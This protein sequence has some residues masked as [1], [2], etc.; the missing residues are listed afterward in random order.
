M[1]NVLLTKLI[2]SWFNRHVSTRATID[3]DGD[4][5]GKDVLVGSDL[6]SRI[7]N[8]LMHIGGCSSCQQQQHRG[9]P[10]CSSYDFIQ[11]N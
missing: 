4:V 11:E 8:P 9:Y 10:G 3:L 2:N 1:P 7:T 6:D 5:E